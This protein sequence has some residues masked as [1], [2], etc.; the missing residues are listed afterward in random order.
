[1]AHGE[2]KQENEMRATIDEAT[3]RKIDRCLAQGG[4]V[5]ISYR[6]DR[7]IVRFRWSTR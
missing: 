7:V 5:I 4:R 3:Q 6:G 1:M 2:P